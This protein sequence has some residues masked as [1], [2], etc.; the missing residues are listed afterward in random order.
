MHWKALYVGS[1]VCKGPQND[2]RRCLIHYYEIHGTRDWN[3]T[4]RKL[5]VQPDQEGNQKRVPLNNRGHSLS[6][7]RFWSLMLTNYHR[8]LSRRRLVRNILIRA[9]Y[10][11]NDTLI[12]CCAQALERS[13]KGLSMHDPSLGII[14]DP[15]IFAWF[16]PTGSPG[17]Y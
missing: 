9:L 11:E 8:L 16:E 6:Y 5:E 17:T 14:K 13:R 12:T 2:A 10:Q 1:D 15:N 7:R 4:F 3:P